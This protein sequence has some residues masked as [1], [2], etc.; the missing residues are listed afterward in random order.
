MSFSNNTNVK[1]T[2]PVIKRSTYL[3]SFFFFFINTT[4]WILLKYLSY[5]DDKNNKHLV[6]RELFRWN[7]D[8]FFSIDLF[9]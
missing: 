6:I 7:E 9:Q 1:I 3:Y 5:L 2:S 4:A 8:I